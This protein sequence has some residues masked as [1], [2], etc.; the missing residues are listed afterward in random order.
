M[1][2]PF[3]EDRR[4]VSTSRHLGAKRIAKEV[5][6]LLR[7]IAM[8]IIVL[9]VH[10]P[11]FLRIEF[12][13]FESWVVSEVLKDRS[14]RGLPTDLYYFRS[15]KGLEVDLLTETSSSVI[16][17]EI[18]AGATIARDFFEPLLK[19]KALLE[20]HP[21]ARDIHC[22]VVYGGDAEQDR[23]EASII[24]WEKVQQASWG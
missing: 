18:K 20:K 12:K 9:A 19:L 5:E 3:S 11:G 4:G 13:L 2:R 21:I 15:H 23:L 14:H 1:S 24:P 6:L 22:R 7:V 17:A 8:S 10:D 16:L